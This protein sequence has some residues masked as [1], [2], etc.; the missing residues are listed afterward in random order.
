[1][2]ITNIRTDAPVG[3]FCIYAN[4]LGVC[5]GVNGPVCRTAADCPASVPCVRECPKTDFT[6]RLSP[7]QTFSFT[8]AQAGTFPYRCDIHPSMQGTVAVTPQERVIAVGRGVVPRRR[9][10]EVRVAVEVEVRCDAA[11]APDGEVCSG[12]AATGAP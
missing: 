2:Q 8:F 10:V 5:G 6:F 1:M 3:L 12:A 4:A 7:G 11:V 9:D